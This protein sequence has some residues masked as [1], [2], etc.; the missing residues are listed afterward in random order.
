MLAAM[1]E[2]ALAGGGDNMQKKVAWA[3]QVLKYIER[4]QSTAGESSRIN[5]PTLVRWTDEALGYIL[6]SAA[7]SNPVPLVS[8]DLP[9]CV[10]YC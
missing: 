5:D 4:H 3:K 2:T 8:L 7:S 10:N 1:R 9:V 6:S